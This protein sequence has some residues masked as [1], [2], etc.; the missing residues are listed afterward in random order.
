VVLVLTTTIFR[1]TYANSLPARD[2]SLRWLRVAARLYTKS[3]SLNCTERFLR[4]SYSPQGADTIGIVRMVECHHTGSFF[5]YIRHKHCLSICAVSPVVVKAS[6]NCRYPHQANAARRMTEM[7]GT[8][9]L[10][11]GLIFLSN[12]R[13]VEIDGRSSQ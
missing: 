3:A 4:K 13:D 2:N 12:S 10:C 9:W 11:Y 7:Y 5:S 6:P 1:S 8:C